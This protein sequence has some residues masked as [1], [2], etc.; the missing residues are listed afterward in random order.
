MKVLL[1]FSILF[2]AIVGP[3][4]A[5]TSKTA[6]EN[7]IAVLKTDVAVLKTDVAVLKT[8]VAVLKTDV[9]VLKTD[10][11][12]IKRDIQNLNSKIGDRFEHLEKR[13]DSMEKNFDRQNALTIAC[14]AVPMALITIMIAWRSVKDNSLQR[15]IDALSAAIE[16]Q[17]QLTEKVESES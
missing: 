4:H 16:S 7:D 8:D 6:I 1:L 14:I 13:L 15:Q 9:A 2:C 17:Q 3:L 11:A 5:D 10:V 12:V